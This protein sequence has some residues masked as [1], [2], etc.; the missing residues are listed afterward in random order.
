MKTILSIIAMLCI[1]LTASA[2]INVEYPFGE[3]DFQSVSASD[4]PTVSNAL[5][6]YTVDTLT[7][8]SVTFSAS[9]HAALRKGGKVYLEV[10]S[11][12][13]GGTTLAYGG[14]LRGSSSTIDSAKTSVASF[15]YRDPEFHLIGIVQLE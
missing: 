4:T 12:N 5:S 14:D 8:G 13:S 15:I 3:G 6:Y 7:S 1:G 10:V 11:N 2:Q 9:A